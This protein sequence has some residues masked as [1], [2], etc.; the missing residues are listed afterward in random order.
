MLHKSLLDKINNQVTEGKHDY[1]KTTS[2]EYN[3]NL[4]FQT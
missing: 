1:L 2:L 3:Q 4:K